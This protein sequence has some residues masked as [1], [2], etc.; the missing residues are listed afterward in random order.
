MFIIHSDQC[1]PDPRATRIRGERLA[2]LHFRRF[3][4]FFDPA[5]RRFS[6]P[7][8]VRLGC[9]GGS[10]LASMSLKYADGPT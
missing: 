9:G 7:N 5:P 6:P 3:T 2:S 4:A 1:K 10:N 8:R